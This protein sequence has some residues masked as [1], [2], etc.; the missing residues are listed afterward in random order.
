MNK[1]IIMSVYTFIIIILS[2]FVY[3]PANGSPTATMLRLISDLVLS[4]HFINLFIDN[5]IL[6][7][8]G[9]CVQRTGTHS[10]LLIK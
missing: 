8:D 10:I 5:T 7:S 4:I 2:L 6:D 9:R 1:T 3:D